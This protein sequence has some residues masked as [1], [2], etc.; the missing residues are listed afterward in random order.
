[1]SRLTLIQ[2]LHL[3]FIVFDRLD[4]SDKQAETSL[5][6]RLEWHLLDQLK[7][8]PER[9]RPQSFVADPLSTHKTEG[10]WLLALVGPLRLA[11]AVLQ[12]GK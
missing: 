8:L 2:L 1:M 6:G 12:R 5:R 4:E 11:Q 7:R 10:D 9:A 3:Y